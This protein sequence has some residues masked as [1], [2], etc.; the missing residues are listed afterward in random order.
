[1]KKYLVVVAAALCASTSCIR[2]QVVLDMAD[3]RDSLTHI[4]NSKDS[5]IGAV[6]EQI[7]AIAESLAQ[8]KKRE[9]MIAV[10]TDS[11]GSARL[12]RQ[13]DGDIAAIDRLLQEN[14]S[15]IA[16]LQDAAVK[17]RKANLKVDG[18]EKMVRTLQEQ[19]AEKSVEMERLR[20]QL[21]DREHQIAALEA[22][23]IGQQTEMETLNDENTDLEHRLHAVYYI[24][25]SERELRDA[26]IIDKEGFIG[27][28]LT[29]GRSGAIDSFTHADTR[30]LSEIP[31]GHKR[32]TMVS[33]HPE[34]S[35]Q[36]VIDSDKVVDKLVITDPT[37]FWESSR[38]LIVSYK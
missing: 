12:F 6:F 33:A 29:V 8:I 10:P 32:A 21:T 31:V 9:N 11:E 28:T 2:K 34:G 15:K 20:K 36:W 25:G 30:L 7:N 38:M 3:Q 27:R 19:V 35:Y 4:V 1:M 17:L 22:Q 23:V 26:Q 16:S 13:I 14:R 18:L 24:V 37:R 5:L